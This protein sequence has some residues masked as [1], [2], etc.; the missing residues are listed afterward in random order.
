MSYISCNFFIV[1]L[2]I[3]LI[4]SKNIVRVEIQKFSVRFKNS[5]SMT[6]IFAVFR[7]F[8]K[9]E[10]IS[11]ILRAYYH[12]MALL[13]RLHVFHFTRCSILPL[14][15]PK[16]KKSNFSSLFKRRICFGDCLKLIS[17]CNNFP[18]FGKN[19]EVILFC[20]FDHSK[21]L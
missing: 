18:L 9:I 1:T 16:K 3:C 5:W 13:V 11:E 15:Q 14:Y 19:S 6:K 12:T 2:E 17:R 21:Y 10:A 20:I 7:V 4:L 8:R